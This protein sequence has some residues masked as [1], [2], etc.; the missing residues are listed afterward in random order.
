MLRKVAFTLY[1]VSDMAAARGFYEGVLGLESGAG[2]ASPWV[3]YDLPGGGC[4]AIT[5]VM[6]VSPH[7]ASGAMIA[8]EVND[9]DA[10]IA[11][12]R[13]KGGRIAEGEIVKGPH[14]RMINVFDPDGNTM[15]LHQL[16]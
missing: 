2:A 10:T 1:M 5:T 11:D 7:P 14:C 15:I 4:F 16:D 8:F 12:V 9:L 6:P 13:A 3:E